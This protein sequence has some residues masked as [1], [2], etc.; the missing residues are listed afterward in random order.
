MLFDVENFLV[1]Q[2][3]DRA[4][5]VAVGVSGGPDSM[6]LVHALGQVMVNVR[7]ITVDHGLRPE[8]AEEAVQVGSWLQGT[9]IHHHILT[10]FVTDTD[11][12][13]RIQE[14]AR[15][16]RYRLMADYCRDHGIVHLFLAHHQDDQ[17]ETVLFRFAK[18]SGLDGLGGM[19]PAQPYGDHLMLMRPLLETSKAEILS[20]CREQDI[21]FV[22]DPSNENEQFARPRLR[23]S[24]QVLEEEGLTTDRITKTASRMRLAKQALEFYSEKE[25]QS[26]LESIDNSRIVFNFKKLDSVPRDVRIR[27]LKRAIAACTSVDQ[28]YGPRFEKLENLEGQIF[29][30]PDFK[31]GTLGGCIFIR[32]EK[33]DVLIVEGE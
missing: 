26:S 29:G 5:P 31:K 15:D 8:A 9:N 6:A 18:G 3:I 32:D 17:A 14:K 11:K 27:V 4:A 24:R 22:S 23:K 1:M 33:Q 25:Y 28:N 10:R 7:A 12:D 21:P 30:S 16:D 2:G 20:F 19:S 13:S